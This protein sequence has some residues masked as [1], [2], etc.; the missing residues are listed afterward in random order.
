MKSLEELRLELNAG[1][2]DDVYLHIA[3]NGQ[4]MYEPYEKVI[5][6]TS[7]RLQAVDDLEAL[8]SSSSNQEARE[9]L[10]EVYNG[11]EDKQVKKAAG[12]VL[13]YSSFRIWFHNFIG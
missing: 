5:P 1:E 4:G 9:L 8:A 13:G 10:L 2:V 12:R 6:D 3:L 11:N 7:R